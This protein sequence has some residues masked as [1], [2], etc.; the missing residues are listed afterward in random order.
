MDRLQK[1]K[2]GYASYKS[3]GLLRPACARSFLQPVVDGRR[4][5]ALS[6]RPKHLVVRDGLWPPHHEEPSHRT[7]E[8]RGPLLPT[9]KGI[10]LPLPSEEMETN[11]RYDQGK[12][13]RFPYPR[14]G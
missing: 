1:R 7:G 11:P 9:G 14:K 5:E 12:R 2:A 10:A 8:E 13:S 3:R 6:R 4:K